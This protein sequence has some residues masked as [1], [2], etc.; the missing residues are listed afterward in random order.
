MTVTDLLKTH[1]AE[2]L[3]ARVKREPKPK[4]KKATAKRGQKYRDYMRE[5]MRKRRN[6]GTKPVGRPK[7]GS[8]TSV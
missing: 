6:S 2:E 5:Y 1:T 8:K 4:R 3:M 7:G